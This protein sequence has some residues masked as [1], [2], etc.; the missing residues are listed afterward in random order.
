MTDYATGW[1]DGRNASAVSLRRQA[2]RLR[3]NAAGDLTVLANASTLEI[4]ADALAEMEPE[5]EG[6]IA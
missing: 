1:S 5:K 3:A 4:A 2:R 6:A